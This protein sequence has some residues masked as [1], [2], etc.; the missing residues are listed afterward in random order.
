MINL[1][2]ISHIA[3]NLERVGD[4]AANIAEATVFLVEGADIRH[5]HEEYGITPG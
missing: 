5:K 3:Q 1:M 2:N 4:N